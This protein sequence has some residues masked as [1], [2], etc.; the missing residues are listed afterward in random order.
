MDI[1]SEI[2]KQ[3]NNIKFEDNSVYLDQ[4]LNHIDRA[5]KYYIQ[6]QQDEHFFNDVI[7]R[8]NQAFE[9]A[10]KEAYKVLASKEEGEL[11]NTTPYKI[12]THFKEN[13][14]F[15]ERVL[16][17]FE[18]YRQEWRNKSTHDYKIIF[19]ESEAFIALTSV[20]SFVH[21]LLK[22]IQE[23]LAFNK[24]QKILQEQKESLEQLKRTVLK[25]NIT[26]AEKI[27]R[28]LNQFIERNE[29]LTKE[30][31]TEIEILGMIHGFLSM[32][33]DEFD[34]VREPKIKINNGILRP[35]FIIEYD[36]EKVIL[37]IKKR[38]DKQRLES[39]K[40][41]VLLY[42][43]STEITQGI[44]YFI[45]TVEGKPFA[46]ISTETYKRNNIEY[47]LFIIKT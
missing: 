47:K 46:S 4:I 8:S 9:G 31:L 18:N 11:N 21:L 10:L 15:R 43:E 40:E 25:I 33:N 14:I 7:Y 41:Q 16:Q 29:F 1:S 32:T 13:L 2:K 37:E 28:L 6:G 27:S 35:D 22:Q 24:E 30:S 17:L 23:K 36:N 5:E 12:E 34:I 44:L 26:L 45:K 20:S 19:N 42:L 3:I 38:F 39:D